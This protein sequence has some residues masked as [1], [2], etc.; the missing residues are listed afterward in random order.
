MGVKCEWPA[1]IDTPIGQVELGR[2]ESADEL[3]FYTDPLK[4]AVLTHEGNK[5]ALIALF[6]RRSRNSWRLIKP[7]FWAIVKICPEVECETEEHNK[8]TESE[9]NALIAQVLPPVLQWLDEHREMVSRETLQRLNFKITQACAVGD[10]AERARDLRDHARLIR[11]IMSEDFSMLRGSWE[12]P[13]RKL[14]AAAAEV[15]TLARKVKA[16][17]CAV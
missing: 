1:L 9:Q 10:L 4:Q 16:L 15:A 5:Y 11:E 17:R 8:I 6:L 13:V 7:E 2:C 3:R 12:T 14:R